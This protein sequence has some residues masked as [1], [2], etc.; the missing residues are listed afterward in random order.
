MMLP[1]C[2]PRGFARGWELIGATRV[3]NGAA[4][5]LTAILDSAAA[6]APDIEIPFRL[7]AY[8][9]VTALLNKQ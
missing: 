1:L 6:V 9:I 5:P 2:E 7:S 4:A 8:A 3:G